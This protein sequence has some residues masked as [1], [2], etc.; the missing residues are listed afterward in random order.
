MA[1]RSF[2]GDLGLLIITLICYLSLT[3]MLHSGK[4]PSRGQFLT[5]YWPQNKVTGPVKCFQGGFKGAFVRT[6]ESL[7]KV[8]VCG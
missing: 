5:E 2:H 4:S 3:L 7:I 8:I 6:Y 1:R